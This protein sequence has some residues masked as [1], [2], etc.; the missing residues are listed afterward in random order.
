[1]NE[2]IKKLSTKIEGL[3]K[4]QSVT[5]QEV[6]DKI[7]AISK[8]Q[9]EYFKYLGPENFIKLVLYV[10]SLKET[11]GFELGDK[12]INKLIFAEL[13]S[14]DNSQ[15]TYECNN[16]AGSGSYECED[17]AGN[18]RIACSNCKESG[19]ITCPECDGDGRQMG[20]NEWENCDECKGRKKIECDECRGEGSTVCNYCSGHREVNCLKCDALGELTSE[21]EVFYSIHTIVTWNKNIQNYCEL[22][23]NDNMPAMSEYEFDRL[24]DEY[25]VLFF[26]EDKHAPLDI[27]ENNMY[28]IFYDDE[29][30]LY[31]TSSMNINLQ[32]T[33]QHINQLFRI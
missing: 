18:G 11:G 6:Y 20:D 23:H 17:C 19:E 9:E 1:M 28:C 32:I 30:K 13:V 4:N 26:E 10:Y 3:I 2:K 14:T 33:K 27:L 21:D 31:F 24:R 16:C 5:P 22:R 15:Y 8:K 25:I 7:V 12:W 29:P